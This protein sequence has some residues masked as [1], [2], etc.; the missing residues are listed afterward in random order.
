MN[1]KLKR[2]QVNRFVATM[3]AS[4]FLAITA[5][6]RVIQVGPSEQ[7]KTIAEAAK[8]AQDDDVVEIAPGEYLGDVAIWL[9]KR[10]IIR[11]V[12]QRPV[13]NAAGKNA[14]GKATWVI[15]NGEFKI[16]NIEFRGARAADGNGAGIRFEKG[17]LNVAHC[18][19][20]DNQN[21]LLTAN[22]EDAELTIQNSIFAQAPKQQKPL[23]HLLY[24]GRIKTLRVVNSRFHGGYFGHLLK[25]RA[26]VSD[27][28]YNLLVDGVGGSASYEAEFPNGGDVTLVGNVMG[29]SSHTENP[30]LLAYGAEG[31]TWPENKLKI[32]HNTFYSEGFQPAWF[33]HVFAE[34]FA[35][36]PEIVTRNNL[37]AGVGVF[38]TN[39]AGQHHGNFAALPTVFGDPDVMDFTLTANSWLRGW[40]EP[41]T[42]DPE[43]L[44][45][46]FEHLMPGRVSAIQAPAK[47]APGAIQASTFEKQ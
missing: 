10:L 47:W 34:K 22:F 8:L 16:S 19:F 44:Q 14:E 20:F 7:I 29:Q 36:A 12:G 21:G 30:T 33:L 39:V 40:V 4:F 41:L 46:K 11:G 1:A 5:A 28:R 43:G 37:L 13:L 3:A 26:R 38:S 32:V 42:P 24:V 17:K 15:R 23:A 31:N 45:P 9:Q 6:A 27:I 2:R 35:T 25:S 18:A